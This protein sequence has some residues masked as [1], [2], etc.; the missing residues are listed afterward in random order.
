MEKI[1]KNIKKKEIILDLMEKN[2]ELRYNLIENMMK[3]YSPFEWISNLF[4]RNNVFKGY[5]K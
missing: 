4:K 3:T 2:L 1:N 5:K